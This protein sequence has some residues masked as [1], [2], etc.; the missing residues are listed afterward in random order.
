MWD[1]HLFADG[2]E[3]SGR[4][5]SSHEMWSLYESQFSSPGVFDPLIMFTPEAC[6]RIKLNKGKVSAIIPTFSS[7]MNCFMMSVFSLLIRSDPNI[8][9]HVFVSINGPDSREGGHELQ[10]RKQAFLEDLRSCDWSSRKGF[11]P[12]AIT[13]SRTWSRIGHAQ[14]LDQ[15]IPWVDTEFY[16]SMHDDVIVVDPSWCFLGDFSENESLA[17]KTWGNHLAG[18][19]RSTGDRLDMPH[20]NTIFTLCRKP[21]MTRLGVGWVG[22]SIDYKFNISEYMDLGR[23]VEEH[24]KAHSLEL[25]SNINNHHGSVSLDIGAFIF[26]KIFLSGL[27]IG[28]FHAGTVR[29]FE[30]ASWKDIKSFR[31][32]EAE[33]LE[34]EIASHDQYWNI[35]KRYLEN[36]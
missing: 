31:T 14:A 17:M 29:H 21:I 27:D 11:N 3:V 10:D 32:P 35:Y 7:P 9:D 22:H 24:S 19:L 33:S 6:E 20:L 26:S 16:L 28:R 1:C 2:A 23:L 8:L 36:G 13:I 12:G 5:L 30:S 34:R 25:G 4:R 15:C 18:R